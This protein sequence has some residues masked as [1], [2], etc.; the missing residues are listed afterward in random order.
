MNR[1]R[2]APSDGVVSPPSNLKHWSNTEDNPLEPET[3]E[4]AY[5]KT[6]DISGAFVDSLGV[7]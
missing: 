4:L 5:Q 2:R 7:T 3:Q 1:R 6:D